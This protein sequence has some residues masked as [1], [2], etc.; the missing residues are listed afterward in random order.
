MS[1]L[2]DQPHEIPFR[3]VEHDDFDPNAPLDSDYWPTKMGHIGAETFH[4]WGSK[5]EEDDHWKDQRRKDEARK[6]LGGFG[7]GRPT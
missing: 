7:F 3:E 1:H 5:K 2:P 4:G 6:R